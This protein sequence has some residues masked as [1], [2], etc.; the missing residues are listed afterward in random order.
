MEAVLSKRQPPDPYQR[1]RRL[2]GDVIQNQKD[3]NACSL[4]Y[5][6]PSL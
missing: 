1:E 2:V 4:P 6:Y 5:V 3:K